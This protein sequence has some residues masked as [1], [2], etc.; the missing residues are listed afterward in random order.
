MSAG[1]LAIVFAPNVL[2]PATPDLNYQMRMPTLSY[3]PLCHLPQPAASSSS[4]PFSCPPLVGGGLMLHTC[5][6]LVEFAIAHAYALAMHLDNTAKPKPAAP[7]I[8]S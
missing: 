1:N 7:V 8:A 2:C 4:S 6:A 5:R 3:A